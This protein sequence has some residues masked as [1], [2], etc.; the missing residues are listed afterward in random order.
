MCTLASWQ[1][2]A[3]LHPAWI[4]ESQVWCGGCLLHSRLGAAENH[5]STSKSSQLGGQTLSFALTSWEIPSLRRHG[6]GERVKPNTALCFTSTLMAE[7]KVP[8]LRK[9]AGVIV[10]TLCP[11]N[12]LYSGLTRKV[13]IVRMISSLFRICKEIPSDVNRHASSSSVPS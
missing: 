12:H 13:P 3:R 10:F 1:Q 4:Q 5:V 9:K 11:Q 6:S 7:W 2:A 8:Y